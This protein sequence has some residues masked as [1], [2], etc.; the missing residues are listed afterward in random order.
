MTDLSEDRYGKTLWN[1]LV[2]RLRSPNHRSIA[3]LG[4]N[5]RHTYRKPYRFRA[6]GYHGPPSA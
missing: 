6:H 1:L 5:I 4:P 3:D 2:R